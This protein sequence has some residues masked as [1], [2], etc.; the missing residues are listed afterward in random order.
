M[1]YPAG[2]AVSKATYDLL[3]TASSADMG[4]MPS[5][6]RLCVS[7]SLCLCV[8]LSVCPSLLCVCA[9]ACL[10]CLCM[11]LSLS[12]C[13]SL[14]VR[15]ALSPLCSLS[16][17]K[18]QT[19]PQVMNGKLVLWR[20]DITKLRAHAIVNAANWRLCAGGGA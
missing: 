6:V 9:C 11:C 17:R 20:G 8:C 15:Y 4:F 12:L 16:Q 5:A 13:E 3:D 19:C 18:L 1:L 2:L 14:S 7:I 10:V